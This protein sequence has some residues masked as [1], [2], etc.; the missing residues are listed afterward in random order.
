MYSGAGFGSLSLIARVR[1]TL[2]SVFWSADVAQKVLSGSFMY[3]I[4]RAVRL[5]TGNG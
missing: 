5:E 4:R 1:K 2:S 3:F